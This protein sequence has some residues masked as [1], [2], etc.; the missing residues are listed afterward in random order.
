M[1]CRRSGDIIRRNVSSL[2]VRDVGV[3]AVQSAF[4]WQGYQPDSWMTA[5]LE[6]NLEIF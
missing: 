5:I 3:S 6:K 4:S 2:M 1:D